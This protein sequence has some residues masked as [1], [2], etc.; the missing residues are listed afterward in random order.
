M[1][2][3][4]ATLTE[5]PA[6]G[7][8]VDV[9]KFSKIINSAGIVGL[10]TLL[11]SLGIIFFGGGRELG[12]TF[13]YSWLFACYFFLRNQSINP[14]EAEPVDGPCIIQFGHAES[15]GRIYSAQKGRAHGAIRV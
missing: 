6:D 2:D 10:L 11:V 13:S 8:R 1:A 7:E 9:S 14:P 5:L 15:R 12:K 3:H 4:G